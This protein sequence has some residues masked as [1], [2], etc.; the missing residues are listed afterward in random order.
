MG[1]EH[2]RP[3]KVSN[4]GV[5]Y[6]TSLVKNLVQVEKREKLPNAQDVI[7]VIGGNH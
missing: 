1:K 5:R 4:L 7:D 6:S 3:Y 2:L